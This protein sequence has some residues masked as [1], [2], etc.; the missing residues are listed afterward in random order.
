[1]KKT[2]LSLGLIVVGLFLLARA[3]SAVLAN[4]TKEDLIRNSRDIL[5]GTVVEVRSEWSAEHKEIF[6]Y[7]TVNVKAQ[8]KGAPVK[9][10]IEL[11]IPGGK[12][13][14]V[15]EKV[16][17]TPTLEPGSEIIVYTFLKEN[18]HLWIYGWKLGV[19]R[20]ADNRIIEYGITVDQFRQLIHRL[21]P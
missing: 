10:Q 1:M 2:C 7:V 20:V 9:G 15:F 8:F 5:L 21:V 19:L 13:G 14:E 4:L 6:T 11:Q 12:V 16:S 18:G 17:D 3:S